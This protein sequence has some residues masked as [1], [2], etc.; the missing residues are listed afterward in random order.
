M[1]SLFISVPI[2]VGPIPASIGK[3]TSLAE[4]WLEK[5]Q[6]TG[7]LSL[8][9]LGCFVLYYYIALYLLSTSAC[10]ICRVYA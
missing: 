5:N 6:L 7:Q 2:P 9:P 1:R 4:L 8:C 3:L 10:A